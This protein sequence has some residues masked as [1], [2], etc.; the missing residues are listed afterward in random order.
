MSTPQQSVSRATPAIL[1]G[2]PMNVESTQSH[3][4]AALFA[5]PPD[6]GASSV[7]AALGDLASGRPIVV[8]DDEDRENEGD[9]VFAAE[10][11][12]AETLALAIRHGS[13]VVCVAMEGT[14][15]DRLN[16]PPMCAQ[17]E[18]PKGTAYAV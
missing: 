11:A 17:N 12:S 7:R 16:L 3:S 13:G 4:G 5:V 9:L 8:V 6:A 18:D 1:R 10:Y 15:L 14:D 2:E